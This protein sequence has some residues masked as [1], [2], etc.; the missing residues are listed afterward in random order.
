MALRGSSAVRILRQRL[1]RPAGE[2]AVAAL[3]G[4]D[5][6]HGTTACR[7]YTRSSAAMQVLDVTFSPQQATLGMQVA[8]ALQRNPDEAASA[9]AASLTPRQ[10]RAL[11][12]AL[13]QSTIAD[14]VYGSSS[15]VDYLF[16]SSDGDAT[17]ASKDGALNKEEFARALR[18]HQELVGAAE[19][20]QTATQATMAPPP[21]TEATPSLGSLTTYAVARGMPFVGF[22]LMD[23]FLMIVAGE[24]IDLSLGAALGLSTMAAAGL[25]NLVSDVAGLGF[26]DTME[27]LIRKAGFITAPP[28]T[29]TQ[30]Q[31]P[32]T[33]VAK[34]LGTS[35]GISIGCLL[36]MFP[37]LFMPG[38]S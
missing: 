9:V 8:R 12:A 24:A 14:A 17:P 6:V 28:L 4:P 10:R 37:L 38:A 26:A 23:N 7:E 36:G 21:G 35:G 19:S 16:D 3:R 25:G 32:R 5:D 22:G 34:L 15:Y 30:R 27:E 11:I 1:A 2:A 18:M 33:R 13:R 20:Q 31:M 29:R